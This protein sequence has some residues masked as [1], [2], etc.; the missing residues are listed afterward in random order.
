MIRTVLGD[1]DPVFGGNVQC[2][3]H[4]LIQKGRSFTVNPALWMDDEDASTQEL[5]DYRKAGGGLIVDAQP[6]F[7]GRMP[8][9]LRRISKQSGVPIVAVTG[10]HKRQFYDDSALFMDASVSKL[11]D[12]FVSDL[13]TGMVDETGRPSE[14]RSGVLKGALE[15]A[16]IQTDSWHERRFLA[17]TEAA[18]RV[19]APV[20]FHI[21]PGADL[22]GLLRFLSEKKINPDRVILCHVDRTH[23]DPQIHREL[24][25]AGVR[26]NY[27]SICRLKYVSHAQ[28]LSLIS[29]MCQ[30]GFASRITLS[31]DTTRAR[32]SAYGGV[33]GLTYILKGFCKIMRGAGISEEDIR[34]MTVENGLNALS[35]QKY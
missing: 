12:L 11:T 25:R 3:E 19:G 7:T 34:K 35:F 15:A 28:E 6:P 2:H 27:D 4:L 30:E 23:Q 5:R 33:I 16:G 13:E 17:L 32:L 20:M 14:G 26:L 21:D 31:L 8:E 29:T 1:I 22:C 24:L 18:M 10:F 9:G